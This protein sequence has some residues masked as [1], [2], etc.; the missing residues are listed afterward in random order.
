MSRTKLSLVVLA[1]IPLTACDRVDDASRLDADLDATE[2]AEAELIGMSPSTAPTSMP[3]APALD[4]DLG[5]ASPKA[6]T[7]GMVQK[8]K[9]ADPEH[10]IGWTRW[11]LAQPFA[12]GAV[13]DPTGE[14][15]A[16]GQDGDIFY[17]AGTFGGAVSRECDVPA[18]KT[19]AFPL[20][21][22][23][24]VFPEEYYPG[25][26]GI[27][28]DM[29][30]VEA[31]YDEAR[32]ATCNLTLE[33]DGQQVGGSLEERD[34][35]FYLRVTEPFEIDL[36]EAHWAT[37]WF[38]GGV[39]PTTGDGHYAVVTPLPPGDHVIVLGGEMC[40]DSP[41]STSA[42]YLLHVGP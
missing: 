14:K 39:M 13:A 36:H 1:C 33:I 20:I 15:C 27:E 6:A 30:L 2:L 31:W 9:P 10:L 26:E 34:E 11:A 35:A 29:P 24:C 7:I 32:A 23:W 19:L 38:A 18:G 5:A 22:R 42:S 28:A 12:D 37:Q 21:N 40:G 4:L 8:V 17:L 16:M 25:G 41:F 3:A